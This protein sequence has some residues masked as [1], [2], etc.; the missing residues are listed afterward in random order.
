[1]IT[2]TLRDK[3]SLIVGLATLP[4]HAISWK[5]EG[6][7]VTYGNYCFLKVIIATQYDRMSWRTWH[8]WYVETLSDGSV[9]YSYHTG[10]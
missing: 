2:R 9:M 4:P 6:W 1:M 7:A 8:P 10:N 3:V 5:Y